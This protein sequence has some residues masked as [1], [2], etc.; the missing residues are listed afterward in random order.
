MVG[1]LL[2][3]S[4]AVQTGRV[5]GR[6][7]AEEM[8]GHVSSRCLGELGALL[9]EVSYSR[10]RSSCCNSLQVGR[11]APSLALCLLFDCPSPGCVIRLDAMPPADLVRPRVCGGVGCQRFLLGE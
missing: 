3:A 9:K 7:V 11:L 2:V 8:G 1:E 5:W 6:R 10:L 4:Q